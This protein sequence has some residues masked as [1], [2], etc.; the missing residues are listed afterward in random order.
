[1][2]MVLSLEYQLNIRK[3]ED[4]LRNNFALTYIAIGGRCK[5]ILAKL[6]EKH[7]HTSKR[8]MQDGHIEELFHA[9]MK[10]VSKFR[11]LD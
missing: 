8:G 3:Q 10:E 9:E 7:G 4:K 2:A 5:T 1:M 6:R 11:K